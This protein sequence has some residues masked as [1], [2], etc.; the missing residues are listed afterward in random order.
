MC[1]CVCVW[2]FYFCLELTQI[3][4][5]KI[6][7]TI[8]IT[9]C[10]SSCIKLE[11]VLGVYLLCVHVIYYQYWIEPIILI[12]NIKAL[13]NHV[14]L[15]RPNRWPRH[16]KESWVHFFPCCLGTHW[17]RKLLSLLRTTRQLLFLFL[18][19]QTPFSLYLLF[20]F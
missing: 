5:R 1:V 13:L 11:I 6:R 16:S 18:Y 14:S 3:S 17:P 8:R 20:S 4:I 15:W 2:P 9:M 19:Q 12:L 7:V 10:S